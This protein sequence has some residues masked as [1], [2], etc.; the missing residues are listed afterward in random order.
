MSASYLSLH[1]IENRRCANVVKWKSDGSLYSIMYCH[2]LTYDSGS[3]FNLYTYML[4]A[5][6]CICIEE[7]EEKQVSKYKR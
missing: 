5:V 1:A 3:E 6:T 4:F 2:N 7:D